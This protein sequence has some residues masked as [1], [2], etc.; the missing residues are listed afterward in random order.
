MRL[1]AIGCMAVLVA[2][3][4]W[5]NTALS[6]EQ[7][8]AQGYAQCIRFDPD[9]RNPPGVYIVNQ[10]QF[11]LDIRW[12]DKKE[13]RNWNCVVSIPAGGKSYFEDYYPP[14]KAAACQAPLYPHIGSNERY[15]CEPFQEDCAHL[16]PDVQPPPECRQRPTASSQLCDQLASQQK[17]AQAA[18]E[19]K[20]RLASAPQNS[21]AD[22]RRVY[23]DADHAATHY[24]KI[25]RQHAL[26]C[27]PEATQV[28]IY[29]QIDANEKQNRDMMAQLDSRCPLTTS[30]TGK[31]SAD[32]SS[33]GTDCGVVLQHVRQLLAACQA[34]DQADEG[35][36][37]EIGN[38]GRNINHAYCANEAMQAAGSCAAARTEA[39]NV[40]SENE[41]GANFLCPGAANTAIQLCGVARG[42]NRIT[43]GD[44]LHSCLDSLT[45][46]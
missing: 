29:A 20:M 32:Q 14:A 33:T 3:F 8:D 28:K 42:C 7:N 1:L 2:V 16:N 39:T 44:G 25:A 34:G 23:S 26:H 40:C 35:H 27:S 30:V 17:L 6:K 45:G 36:F 24:L 15:A 18:G 5:R 4:T 11:Q 13:C 43:G 22:A 31:D 12:R 37:R 21:C 41:K 10:C 38:C 9:P 46:K 19:E